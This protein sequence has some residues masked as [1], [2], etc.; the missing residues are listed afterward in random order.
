MEWEE[1]AQ[2]PDLNEA[3]NLLLPLSLADGPELATCGHGHGEEQPL[4]DDDKQ[5]GRRADR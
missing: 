3:A 2:F 1:K 5:A 4:Q